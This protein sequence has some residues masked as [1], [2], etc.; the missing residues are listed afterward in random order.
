MNE[1]EE[2]L[3]GKAKEFERPISVD[4]GQFFTLRAAREKRLAYTNQ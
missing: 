1:I 3:E 4:D 2:K